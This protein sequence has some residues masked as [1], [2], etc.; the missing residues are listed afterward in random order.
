[1]LH[2]SRHRGFTLIELLV[3]IAII[4][5][6]VA[7]L[8]PAV[9]QARE[10]ARRSQCKNNFKQVGL[11]IHNYHDTHSIFP[12]SMHW[13]DARGG[14]TWPNGNGAD[15]RAYRFSWGAMILPFLDMSN[16]YNNFD[17]TKDY[18]AAPNVI[19]SK[20]LHTSGATVNV[21][22]CPT[23]PQGDPRCSR[24]GAINNG[25]GDD[26]LGR[27]NMAGVAD[28]ARWSCTTSGQGWGRIDGNGILY[29]G[30]NTRMRD[31]TDGTSG[32]LLVGEV[33][34]GQRG[35]FEC[36]Y[37][38]VANHSDTG[39]GI[40]GVNTTPGGFKGWKTNDQARL[41]S[42]SSYHIGGCHF[43]M[44]DGSVH[45][46]SENIS[47]TTLQALATRSGQEVPGEF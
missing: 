44:A 7:L 24:T 16:L 3:V 30:N 12:L 31:V 43:L 11:A 45:F 18:N 23:D 9:Q 6:L 42:F 10:A 17:F 39:N 5:V 32:T 38:S 22:L 33:T 19:S 37:W 14:C 13:G 2:S 15:G 26:D 40:N 25:S 41:Q 35:D 27:T 34:G 47:S 20:S 21:Y 29:N 8:L 28:S 46:I 1:M 4:A 36:N